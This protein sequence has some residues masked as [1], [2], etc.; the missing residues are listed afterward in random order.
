MASQLSF[1]QNNLL[2]RNIAQ[3]SKQGDKSSRKL[4]SN[5][6]QHINWSSIL[7]SEAV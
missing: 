3:H 7:I 1:S 4:I 5:G 6:N 2:L